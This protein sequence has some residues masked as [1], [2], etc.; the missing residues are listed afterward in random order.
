MRRTPIVVL[1]W[2]AGDPDYLL[3]WAREGELPTVA[4][5][6]A[7]GCHW[8][9][10]GPELVCEHG[11]WL[12]IASGVSRGRH[13]YYYYR[14]LEPGTYDVR[15]VTARDI[16]V[17]P[18]WSRLRDSDV[19]TAAIDVPDVEPV[20]GLDGLQLANWA[21]HNAPFPASAE[22]AELLGAI[23]NRFGRERV[24]PENV[25]AS[26][27][28]DRHI[29]RALV[30]RA[31]LKGEL[32]RSL[33][34]NERLDLAFV[35]FGEG[36]T[37]SHQLWRS[38]APDLRDGI[39]E[40][41]REIDRQLGALLAELPAE[42]DVFLVTSV[43]MRDRFPT[44]GLME[45]FCRR[46]G[47]QATPQPG[48]A[49]SLRPAA[50]VRRALPESWRTAASRFLSR[51]RRERIVAAQF[52]AGTDWSRTTAFAIPASYLGFIRV[53]LRGRE[54]L[55][56]VEPG[57]DYEEL[58]ERLEGDLRLL[59]D[60]ATGEPV[61]DHV[62]L[63]ADLYGPEPSPALPDLFVEWRPRTSFLEA[64]EHPRARLEQARPEFLRDSDHSTEGLLIAA[65]PSVRRRGDAG[66]ADPLGLVPTLLRLLGQP[67]PADLAGTP[68][69]L[70]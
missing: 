21:V 53:N 3:D 18:F 52:R 2:D 58:L 32:A 48:G 27:Q 46:L 68:L 1:G 12:S 13:G 36:H 70:A 25:D 44:G 66:T 45:E 19:R 39:R 16:A 64:V 54:P 43:G 35:V 29:Y 47:Y 62:H 56:T 14:Q 4:S 38:D 51:E 15:P 37:A 57:R 59:V 63:T 31:R 6:L 33:V 26:E 7:R 10:G 5:L 30:E 60:P 67:V 24:I 55:G 20:A 40:V 61:V 9:T 11:S 50:L 69:E 22:P 28:E 49:R 23:R 65:G 41:Y 17:Q 42:N 34:A 8:R